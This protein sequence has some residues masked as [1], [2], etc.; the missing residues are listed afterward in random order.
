MKFDFRRPCD[1]RPAREFGADE[2]CKVFRGAAED[3]VGAIGE[4][5]FLVFVVLHDL[6]QVAVQA[7]DDVE[8]GYRPG[9]D[10]KPLNGLIPGDAGFGD[11]RYVGHFTRARLLPSRRTRGT[12]RSHMRQRASMLSA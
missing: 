6:H 11:S 8:R 10:A 3:R 4:K 9:E 7:R 5:A 12:C 1:F 2:R